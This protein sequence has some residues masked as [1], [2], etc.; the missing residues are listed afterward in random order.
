MRQLATSVLAALAFA[1]PS[2]A[3][4]APPTVRSIQV[5]RDTIRFYARSEEYESDET[6]IFGFV[7]ATHEWV[8]IG[9]PVRTTPRHRPWELR[10]AVRVA[11]GFR[12]VGRP[13]PGRKPPGFTRLALLGDD[14]KRYPVEADATPSE[15]WA[16]ASRDPSFTSGFAV[17][18]PRVAAYV[19][20]W[21]R[22]GDALWFSTYGGGEE[23]SALLRFDLAARRFDVAL[24]TLFESL[25]ARAMAATSGAVWLAGTR[26]GSQEPEGGLYSWDAARRVATRFT[27]A[28][29]PLPGDT[30]LALA[31][32]GDTLWVATTEGLALLDAR[33]GQWD[34]RWFRATAGI[35]TV[36]VS[37]MGYTNEEG[38]REFAEDTVGVVGVSFELV[39]QRPAGEAGRRLAYALDGELPSRSDRTFT[40]DSFFA[41]LSRVPAAHFDSAATARRPIARALAH[42]EIVRRLVALDSANEDAY[43]LNSDDIAA[44]GLLGDRAYLPTLQ[45]FPA[46]NYGDEE[47][48]A[49]LALALARLGDTSRVPALRHRVGHGRLGF[50]DLRYAEALR[51]TGDT[52][53]LPA[54]LAYADS[55]RYNSAFAAVRLFASRDQWRAIVG[56][57]VNDPRTRDDFLDWTALSDRADTVTDPVVHRALARGVRLALATPTPRDTSGRADHTAHYRAAAIAVDLRDPAL[58]PALIPLLASDATDWE[59]ATRALIEL[60]GVDTMPAP[61]RPTADQRKAARAFWEKW[62]NDSG[63]RHELVAPAAG[64]EALRRWRLRWE[65][66]GAAR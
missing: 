36:A 38:N 43:G 41:L 15:A 9:G 62:W 61:P 4:V 19:T 10:D 39:P 44:I 5:G 21:A 33:V 25:L 6:P 23:L 32:A 24:D 49:E 60:T 35:D 28:T 53:V 1:R 47:F 45:A 51:E 16:V 20:R 64:Q 2:A 50:N 59:I 29:S 3:Q 27:A 7:R 12:L 22:S 8:R 46:E 54:L 13:T 40:P 14:G 52:T 11:P 65:L 31:A 55:T 34:V 56:R 57:F 66:A 48:E 42:P 17:A 30:V 37:G 26:Y 18:R 58:I 63:G